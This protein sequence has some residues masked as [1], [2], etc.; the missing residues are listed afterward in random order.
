M[1]PCFLFTLLLITAGTA[2]SAQ[3]Q[4]PVMTRL[5]FT[6]V[7][8]VPP[9]KLAG[10]PVADTAT[11]KSLIKTR[12]SNIE[13]YKEGTVVNATALGKVY[14]MPVDRMHCLVPDAA[15]TARMPVKK[16]RMPEPMPNVCAGKTILISVNTNNPVYNNHPYGLQPRRHYC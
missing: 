13:W 3:Q 14:Q 6:P 8:K 11:L 15:K 10:E 7:A 5:E 1:K 12:S 2:A 9:V 4:D 16:T